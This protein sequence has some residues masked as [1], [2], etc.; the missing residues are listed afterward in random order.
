MKLSILMLGNIWP[1]NWATFITQLKTLLALISFLMVKQLKMAINT[2]VP[3]DLL[4]V[5]ATNSRFVFSGCFQND[6]HY[7]TI[8]SIVK[9]LIVDKYITNSIVDDLAVSGPIKVARFFQCLAQSSSGNEFTS[10]ETCSENNLQKGDYAAFISAIN[11]KTANNNAE[12]VFESMQTKTEGMLGI[13]SITT[14]PRVPTVTLNG[15]ISYNALNDLLSEACA[16]QWI[17]SML[18]VLNV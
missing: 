14:L 1:N 4:S 10:L 7:P 17:V 12:K 5:S 9:A 16:Q 13:N 18:K 15:K 2:N 8:Y 6:L 3:R 11:N